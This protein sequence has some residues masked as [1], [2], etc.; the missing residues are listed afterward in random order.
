MTAIMILTAVPKEPS[1]LNTQDSV[2]K[3][4]GVERKGV[5]MT[6]ATPAAMVTM[7]ARRILPMN[8]PTKM[9]AMEPRRREMM[10]I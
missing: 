6:T 3:K 4:K 1:A 2:L 8:F 9:M 7:K 10:M 5:I